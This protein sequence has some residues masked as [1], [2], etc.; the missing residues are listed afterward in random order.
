MFF[1]EIANVGRDRKTN[2]TFSRMKPF[3]VS[4]CV[5][6][7]FASSETSFHLQIQCKKQVEATFEIKKLLEPFSSV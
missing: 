2:N 7:F 1:S 3:C 6:V 5:C 4:V